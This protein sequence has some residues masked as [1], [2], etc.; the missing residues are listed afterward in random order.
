MG[1]IEAGKA[2]KFKGMIATGWSR[3]T[4]LCPQCEPIYGAL[5]I[6]FYAGMLFKNGIPP[7]NGLE[8]CRAALEKIPQALLFKSTN[9]ALEKITEARKIAWEYFWWITE[10]ISLEK[11]D[12]RFK[13]SKFGSSL[14][15][16]M[17]PML[18]N[19]EK[20][21]HD[22]RKVLIK[23]IDKRWVDE[24]LN[25]RV[26][27]LYYAFNKLKTDVNKIEKNG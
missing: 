26:Q 17:T 2:H 6:L 15:D 7:K 24:Y 5:D 20:A 21:C 10:Q 3:Y 13:S 4:T 25:V 8:D 14:I 9:H 23:T 1:W 18:L 22:A 12:P 27:S 16:S 11:Y 19:V